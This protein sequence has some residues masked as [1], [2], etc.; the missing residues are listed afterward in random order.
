[1]ISRSRAVR[2]IRPRTELG[3]I[4]TGSSR[5]SYGDLKVWSRSELPTERHNGEWPSGHRLT[6][7]EYRARAGEPARAQTPAAAR[8]ADQGSAGRSQHCRRGRRS[9][10][11]VGA[12]RVTRMT[13]PPWRLQPP[14]RCSAAWADGG[15]PGDAPPCARTGARTTLPA[16]PRTLPGWFVGNRVHGQTRLEFG[17][18]WDGS[19]QFLHAAEGFKVLGARVFT[20]HVKCAAEDPP[21]P[22]ALPTRISDGRPL[23]DGPRVIR[24]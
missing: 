21:W 5:R 18:R 14:A 24:G 23:S 13:A 3:W 19:D 10:S 9:A 4:L 17:D 22:T 6:C 11:S 8:I 16:P 2:A 1:M 20:R 15:A 7:Q 12:P